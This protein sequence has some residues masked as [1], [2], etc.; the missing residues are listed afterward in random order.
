MEELDRSIAQSERSYEQIRHDAV[1]NTLYEKFKE[2]WN[3]YRKVVNQILILSR[4]GH[5]SEA[6]AMYLSGS[7]AAYNAASDAIA[8]TLD[9]WTIAWDSLPSARWR[10]RTRQAGEL[11]PPTGRHFGW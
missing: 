10:R 6:I 3:A 4:T 9:P 5:K 11:L 2:T 1:E 7:H 8:S